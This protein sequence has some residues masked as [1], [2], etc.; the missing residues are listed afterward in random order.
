MIK[1]KWKSAVYNNRVSEKNHHVT[2]KNNWSI[3]SNKLSN[4]Y[5]N[6]EPSSLESHLVLKCHLFI[7]VCNVTGLN[8]SHQMSLCLLFDKLPL[9][10]QSFHLLWWLLHRPPRSCLALSKFITDSSHNVMFWLEQH[11]SKPQ[12]HTSGLGCRNWQPL[13]LRTLINQFPQF[14]PHQTAL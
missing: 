1:N 14:Q 7:G 10:R 12:R 5:L 2:G 4:V 11:F 8:T 6:R 3:F 13:Q 9:L